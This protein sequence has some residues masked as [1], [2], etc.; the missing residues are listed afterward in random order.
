MLIFCEDTVTLNTSVSSVYGY[1]TLLGVGTGSFLQA[2]FSIA[3]AL[4]A[5]EEIANAVGFMSV[6]KK[7]ATS[8]FA[9]LA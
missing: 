2:G 4:V 5:P 3:Q 7:G 8:W 1:S 9:F 6:G